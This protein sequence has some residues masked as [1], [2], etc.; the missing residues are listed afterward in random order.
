[1]RNLNIKVK[2]M[3]RKEQHETSGLEISITASLTVGLIFVR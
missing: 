2:E 1:M 3:E